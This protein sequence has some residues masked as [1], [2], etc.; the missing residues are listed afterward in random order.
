M[1][2]GS[3]EE[4]VMMRG[5]LDKAK[6][7]RCAFGAAAAPTSAARSEPAPESAFVVTVSVAESS[8]TLS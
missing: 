5:Q 7:I 2:A 8:A 1:I 3:A 6:T 4:T